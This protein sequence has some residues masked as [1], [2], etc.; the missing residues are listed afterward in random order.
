MCYL[1]VRLFASNFNKFTI[2]NV[3]NNNIVLSIKV[4]LCKH[5]IYNK[6][7]IVGNNISMH[8]IET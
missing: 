8:F 6:T 1:F 2:K 7:E 5:L 4:Y 3:N